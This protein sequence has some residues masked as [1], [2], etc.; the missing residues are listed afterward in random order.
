MLPQEDV[1]V[2]AAVRRYVMPG[3]P[4]A[5]LHGW[6]LRHRPAHVADAFV[7][8]AFVADL[9]ERAAAITDHELVCLFHAEWRARLTAA[10]LVALSGRTAFRDLLGKLLIR[11]GNG[12]REAR[13]YVLALTAFGTAEDA[14]HLRH[15]AARTTPGS[16]QHHFSRGWARAGLRLLTGHGE[17]PSPPETELL[18]FL[19]ALVT[20]HARPAPAHTRSPASPT[21][22][23]H[24]WR[25][26]PLPGAWTVIT[27]ESTRRALD[28]RFPFA[29]PLSVATTASGALTLY[30]VRTPTHRWAT[31]TETGGHR[32]FTTVEEALAGLS[33]GD[34]SA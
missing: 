8:D 26:T 31:R 2:L 1:Q 33:S 11:P 34:G 7:A 14:A 16:E 22:R 10:W 21:E 27:P 15:F 17:F 20:A 25:P 23:F 24:A 32:L 19:R 12:G 9:A 5:K 3:R 30:N 6:N 13:G 4:Y 18:A 29:A 28:R